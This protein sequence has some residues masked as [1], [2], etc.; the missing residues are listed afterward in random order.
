MKRLVTIATA[1]AALALAATAAA[2][3]G[4]K[5][6]RHAISARQCSGDGAALLVN[7]VYV[8][9][10]DYD[11]GFAGNAWAN[12]TIGR[13]LQIW[14][15]T[16]G[17][18]CAAVSDLGAFTTFAGPSPSGLSTVSAGV[19]GV[20]TG[21][22]VTTRFTGTFAPSLRTHGFLGTFDLA[23][24]TAYTCP[25]THPSYLSYFSSTSGDDLAHWGWIY[26]AGRHGTWLNQ[27]DVTAAAGGDITG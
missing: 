7:V 27:D 19:R 23:C 4:L 12:D 26:Y 21:G 16:D 8:L 22:Y 3:P 1:L 13:Q 6:D 10:N 14:Q 18:Y 15:A 20:L 17:T 2:A 9:T 5:L 25:G 11:S 24:T